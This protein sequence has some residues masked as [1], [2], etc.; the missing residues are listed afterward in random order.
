MSNLQ[1]NLVR[2]SRNPYR[3]HELTNLLFPSSNGMYRD[4]YRSGWL[5]SGFNQQWGGA[6]WGTE[7]QDS[8]TGQ[9]HKFTVATGNVEDNAYAAIGSAA[10]YYY[11]AQSFKVSEDMPLSNI[12]LKLYKIQASISSSNYLQVY[13]YNDNAGSPGTLAVNG[14]ANLVSIKTVTSNPNGEWYRINFNSPVSLTSNTNYH[15]VCTMNGVDASNYFGWKDNATT[16]KYPHGAIFSGTSVPAWTAYPNAVACFM[17]ETPASNSL[18]QSGGIFDQK[19]GFKE[20]FV[21]QSRSLV[22]PLSKFFDNKEFTYIGAWTDLTKN[23]TFA[24]FQYGLDHDR[25]VL[26]CNDTTGFPQVD[27]YD[28]LGVK[29]TVTGNVDVSSGNHQVGVHIRAFGDAQDRVDLIVDGVVNATLTGL[30]LD[31]DPLFREKGTAWVGGGFDIAPTWTQSMSFST[32]PS[33]Q[34]WTWAGATE[35]NAVSIYNGKLFQNRS[36]FAPT[37][38]GNYAKSAAGLNNTNGWTVQW[39]N[40]VPHSTGLSASGT[41]IVQVFDGT[42]QIQIVVQPNFVQ[43]WNGS[44]DLTAQGDFSSQENVF[45]LS[46]KGSNYFLWINGKLV[47]DGTARLTVATATNS[48]IFGDST[49]ASG[50][51]SDVVWSYMKYTNSAAFTPQATSGYLSEAAYWSGDK[52]SYAVDLY[53]NGSFLSAK[54]YCGLERNYVEPVLQEISKPSL[55]SS[56]STSTSTPTIVA[57]ESNIFFIGSN[58]SYQEFLSLSSSVA[59]AGIYLYKYIDGKAFAVTTL[60]ATASGSNSSAL[61]IPIKFSVPIGLHIISSGLYGSSAGTYTYSSTNSVEIES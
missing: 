59:G 18:I 42:K 40:R 26:R 38:T 55:G 3:T 61:S 45:T 20:G 29:R 17:I 9:T 51:N 57:A 54:K 13:I 14:T 24:D 37:D 27:V 52:T 22:Q 12:W 6:P 10:G 1:Q 32:L 28:T 31:F 23:K 19:F 33:L 41:C 56:T 8:R 34:G 4:T 44:L 58:A 43:S 49:P 47:L 21:T 11:Q 36:G 35:A 39:K 48:I 46:G 16:R 2:Q 60:N 50:E 25:V 30:T 5:P 53:N 7:M 15:I